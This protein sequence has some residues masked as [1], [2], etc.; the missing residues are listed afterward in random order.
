MSHLVESEEE[1]AQITE[2][3]LTRK[4]VCTKVEFIGDF[5]VVEAESVN[6][7]DQG[8]CFEMQEN[9]PFEMRFELNGELHQH[10]AHLVWMK[11]L[12]DGK[13]RCGFQ[14]VETESKQIL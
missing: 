5:D 1:Q 11:R 13:T 7:S 10:R 9:L 8:I 2:D 4:A 14:F 12:E 3:R 6:V